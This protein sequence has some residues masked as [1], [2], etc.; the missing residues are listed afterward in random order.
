MA[1]ALKGLMNRITDDNPETRGQQLWVMFALSLLLV[2]SLNWYAMTRE[3]DVV[4]IDDLLQ[5]KNEVVKVEGTLLSWVK[6]PYS[7]GDDRVDLIIDDGT[8]VVEGRWYRPMPMPPIGTNVVLMGDVIEYDGRIWIQSLGSGAM[9]WSAQDL[10]EVVELALADV[11][12]NPQQYEGILIS[13]SGFISEAIQPDS[14]FTVAYLGDHPTYSN[15]EH[16]MNMIIR[17]ATGDWIE[18]SSKVEV[19]GVLTYQQRDLRWSLQVQ[20]P[21]ILVDTSHPIPIATMDWSGQATWS[22]QSGNLVELTGTLHIEDGQWFASGPSATTICIVATESDIA[23]AQQYGWNN[24]IRTFNGRLLWS[25]AKSQWCIDAVEGGSSDLIDPT[26]AITL[27]SMLGTNPID[28]VANPDATYVISSYIRYSIEPSVEDSKGYLVTS[29]GYSYTQ[30][31]VAATFPGPRSE[32]LEAGQAIVANVSVTWDDKDMRIRLLVNSYSPG[33]TME[34]STLLWSDG[35]VQWG[36]TSN[37]I[38]KLNGKAVEK[39][40]GWYL[41]ED[42]SNKSVKLN[43]ANNAIGVDEIHHNHTLTWQGRLRQ[44]DATDQVALTFSLDFADVLDTD[45]DALADAIELD[46]G[47]SPYSQDSDG[48]GIDDRQQYLDSQTSN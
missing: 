16:Q 47:T 3:P 15:S 7:S 35:A 14:T 45:N 4:P 1:D 38:V 6:D 39:I 11:A 33:T 5:Y 19:R 32:W 8:G 44:V 2:A 21:E 37:Q 30:K 9:E 26:N 29:Q 36:Y 22:Y 43:L 12:I 41:F 46:Y 17:S 34:P 10:P 18:A 40:D 20:G 48:D 28:V 24:S 27:I 13:L 25:E 31:A 23:N 42:G